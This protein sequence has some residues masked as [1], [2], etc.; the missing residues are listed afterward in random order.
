MYFLPNIQNRCLPVDSHTFSG[1]SE[2][3][4]GNDEG[5]KFGRGDC[6]PDTLFA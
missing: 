1:N 4:G 5:E 2:Q 6:K 3:D